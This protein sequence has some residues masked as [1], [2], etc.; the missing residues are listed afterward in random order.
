[1][2]PTHMLI[3]ICTFCV[4]ATCARNDAMS[5]FAYLILASFAVGILAFALLGRLLGT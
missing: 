5:V 2:I 1:M 4:I 3:I